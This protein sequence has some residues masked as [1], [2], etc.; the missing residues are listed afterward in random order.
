MTQSPY[1]HSNFPR[2]PDDNYQTVDPRC[3]WGL[4]E[5]IN[6]KNAYVVDV[7]SPQGSGI[8]DVLQTEKI[9]VYSNSDCFK[10]I[11]RADWIITNPPYTRKLVDEIIWRQIGR[12]EDFKVKGV[13]MLLRSNFDFAKSRSSLFHHELYV[14]Q[15]KLQFRPWWSEDKSQSPIHNFC[16]HIWGGRRWLGYH[17][18]PIVLYSKGN[19]P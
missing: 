15:I 10:P 13:A 1:V 8:I 16:W 7:C 9:E 5:H 14:G 12:I 4:M 6:L 18:Q 11:I 19:K 3:V 2:I 17:K